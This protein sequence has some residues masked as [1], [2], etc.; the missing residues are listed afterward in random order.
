MLLETLQELAGGYLEMCRRQL[1]GEEDLA[2][3]AQHAAQ[4]PAQLLAGIRSLLRSL[5][6]LDEI[7]PQAKLEQRACRMCE[8]LAKRAVDAQMAKLQAALVGIVRG[9]GNAATAAGPDALH[10]V[11]QTAAAAVGGAVRETLAGSAPLLAPLTDV[12]RL[13]P[14]AMA[15]HLVLK[16]QAAL[17]A[18][19]NTALQPC[20]EPTSALLRAGL[21]AQMA[22][23]GVAQVQTL[24]KQQLSPAGVGGAA[25]ALEAAPTQRLMRSAADH[26]LQTFVELQAQALSH[27]L[28]TAV[29]AAS[30]LTNPPPREVSPYVE[31]LLA[32]LRA[33]QSS[34]AQVFPGEAPR[35][36][37]PQGGSLPRRL[38]RR[39]PAR[40]HLARRDPQGDAAHVRAPD[41]ARSRSRRGR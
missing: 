41:L 10:A 16:L 35:A 19:A 13:P 25:L 40:R 31:Q 11:L 34:A 30:L 37:L 2:P 9:L 29:R 18:L 3:P 4:Q 15:S 22:T 39:A 5:A 21:C 26:A 27:E 38:R 8:Q 23:E 36:M 28:Q 20:T 6:P 14:D 33:L 7:A 12:L 17:H 24:L 32:R 1:D